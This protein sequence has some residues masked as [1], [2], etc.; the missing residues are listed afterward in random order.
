MCSA[1]L[2]HMT[3]YP[4]WPVTLKNGGNSFIEGSRI[5]LS[6]RHKVVTLEGAKPGEKA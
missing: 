4:L 6:S 5:G 1:D 3:N 2:G